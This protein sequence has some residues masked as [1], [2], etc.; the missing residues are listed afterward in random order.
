FGRVGQHIITVLGHLNVPRLVVETDIGRAVELDRQGVPTLYGDAADSEVLDHAALSR[1]RALVVT[2]P[3]EA[4]AEVVVA[5]GR[6]Q[7][8]LMPIIARAATQGGIERLFQLGAQDVIHP[9]LE[10]GLEIVRHTLMSLGFPFPEV[11]DYAEAVRRDRYDTS[12]STTTEQDALDRLMQTNNQ[13]H[14]PSHGSVHDSGSAHALTG[15]SAGNS[16]DVARD[17]L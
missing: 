9:E 11:D 5:A 2:L 4:A 6:A 1:A 3:D 15:D 16:A 13:E 8:A 14:I 10:G 7:N 17:P 12:I